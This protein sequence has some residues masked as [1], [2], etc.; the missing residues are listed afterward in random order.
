MPNSIFF[1]FRMCVTRP[2]LTLELM[3]RCV[4]EKLPSYDMP[5]DLEK[6]REVLLDRDATD[7]EMTEQMEIVNARSR[8][9]AMWKEYY[10]IVY[11]M[12][13]WR[14]G[15]H[16]ARIALN[17]QRKMWVQ[18]QRSG[19]PDGKASLMRYLREIFPAEKWEQT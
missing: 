2:D 19:A 16:D 14:L 10:R 15:L 1:F 17:L 13:S 6:A 5:P 12:L 7:E 11:Y 8:C 3:L 4:E 18:L 9:P